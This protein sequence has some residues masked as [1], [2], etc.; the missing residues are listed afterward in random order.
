MAKRDKKPKSAEQKARVA[1]KQTKKAAQK[2]KKTRLKTADGSEAEDVD[3]ESVLEEYSKQVLMSY[4]FAQA[5]SVI[6]AALTISCRLQHSMSHLFIT[7]LS[8]LFPMF[9]C[10]ATLD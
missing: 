2:E 1:A 8:L 5:S 4:G 9:S 10:R 3:L 7:A 6:F